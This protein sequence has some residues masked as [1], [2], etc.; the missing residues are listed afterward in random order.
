MN[1]SGEGHATNNGDSTS[2]ERG[3][4]SEG[5]S[6]R[7]DLTSEEPT[8]RAIFRIYSELTPESAN[9][10]LSM[11]EREQH[12]EERTTRLEF[13]SKIVGRVVGIAAA[14]AS[15]FFLGLLGLNSHKSIPTVLT[16]FGSF[17]TGGAAVYIAALMSVRHSRNFKIRV[18]SHSQD[19]ET[20]GD[21][22]Q[23]VR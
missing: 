18:T 11:V 20:S 8:S 17:V 13:W 1:A 4:D 5:I 2:S 14:I 6:T 10:I 23:D 16:I 12:Y 19:N 15:F 9:R 3:V 22:H 21:S 7:T